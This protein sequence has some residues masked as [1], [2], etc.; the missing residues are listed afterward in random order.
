MGGPRASCRSS[1]VELLIFA[2][3]CVCALAL[4]GGLLRLFFE[5]VLRG[6]YHGGTTPSPHGPTHI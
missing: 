6:Q 3:G 2:L 5:L 1:M 4:A